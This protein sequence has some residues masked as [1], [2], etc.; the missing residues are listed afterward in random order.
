VLLLVISVTP[1]M[2]ENKCIEELLDKLAEFFKEK[3]EGK[4]DFDGEGIKRGA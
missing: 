4:T 2:R 3:E 1:A